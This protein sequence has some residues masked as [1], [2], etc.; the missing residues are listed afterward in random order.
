MASGRGSPMPELMTLRSSHDAT[1]EA[2]TALLELD[3]GEFDDK[4]LPKL[5]ERRLERR[6]VRFF[7]LCRRLTL[8]SLATADSRLF[9]TNDNAHPEMDVV[10]C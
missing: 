10:G 3:K 2:N 5:L 9:V 7:C 8:Q 6:M 1:Q 4:A